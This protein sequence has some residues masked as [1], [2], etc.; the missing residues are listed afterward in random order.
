M[1]DILSSAF[2]FILFSFCLSVVLSLFDIAIFSLIIVLINLTAWYIFTLDVISFNKKE[3]YIFWPSRPRE[4]II[5]GKRM[6]EIRMYFEKQDLQPITTFRKQRLLFSTFLF[7]IWPGSQLLFISFEKKISYFLLF[8][9]CTFW[10][11]DLILIKRYQNKFNVPKKYQELLNR[12]YSH[13]GNYT[14]EHQKMMILIFL[15]LGCL[16]SIVF[17]RVGGLEYL[18]LI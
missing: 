6:K 4:G 10:I 5:W 17:L 13:Q 1:T 15:I 9:L 14:F 3:Q 7:L 12:L 16:F 2:K 18:K 8:S 11:I